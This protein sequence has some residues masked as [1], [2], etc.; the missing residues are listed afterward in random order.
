MTKQL[1]K[2]HS[3]DL[4]TAIIVIFGL[5]SFFEIEYSYISV[6]I[7]PKLKLDPKD[8]VQYHGHYHTMNEPQ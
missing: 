8:H 6:C 2:T 3:N 1:S 7:F 5:S 4:N